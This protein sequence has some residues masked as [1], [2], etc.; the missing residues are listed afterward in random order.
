MALNVLRS[1]F[2]GFGTI[3]GVSSAQTLVDD[4]KYFLVHSR[5]TKIPRRLTLIAGFLDT[6]CLVNEN[7]KNKGAC[8]LDFFGHSLLP[9]QY[10]LAHSLLTKILRRWALL[11]HFL[12]TLGSVK[13]NDKKSSPQAHLSGLPRLD[14][15][16]I[17]IYRA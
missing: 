1:S 17:L 15:F 11:P 2:M 13:E 4:I 8:G 3:L 7:D 12:D 14:F 10:L 5:L 6:L 9:S 16:I